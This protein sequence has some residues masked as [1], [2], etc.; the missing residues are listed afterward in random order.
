M[1]EYSLSDQADDDLDAITVYSA[2]TFGV[3]KAIEYTARL[4]TG[5]KTIAENPMIGPDIS[6][7]VPGRRR[8]PVASH[9][10]YYRIDDVG[11]TI[12]IDRILHKSQD[13]LG[14][15]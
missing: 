2:K 7:A 10:V 11:K 3:D 14:K 9:I 6:H 12:I 5:F 4:I 13:P 1:L 8:F 15:L